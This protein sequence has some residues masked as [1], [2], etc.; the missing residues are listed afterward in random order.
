MTRGNPNP[1][2]DPRVTS[3]SS[4]GAFFYR[5][6]MTSLDSSVGTAPSELPPT[7]EDA[8]AGR[9]DLEDMVARAIGG[10]QQGWAELVA[11][12]QS[13]INSVTHRYRLSATDAADVSQTV[14]TKLVV[15]LP[16][17]RCALALPGWISITTTRECLGVLAD[18]GRVRATDP[19]VMAERGLPHHVFCG[20]SGAGDIDEA[21]IRLETAQALRE[22][23]AELPRSQRDLLTLLVA[24]PPL[25]YAQISETL[26][27][28]VGSIGPT[29]ARYLSR[30]RKTAAVKQ[31][32][33]DHGS[34]TNAA[35]A[36]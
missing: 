23:L 9:R 31:L 8:D 17:L 32:L 5:Q 14:W 30:L 7:N 6:R 1:R 34:A 35:V 28:P 3:D 12:F 22:G 33:S 25:S 16:R 29:R 10:D 11:R 13:L 21:L 24:D 26:A 19:I 15:H 36:A 20:V 2:V 4:T 18:A 27:M